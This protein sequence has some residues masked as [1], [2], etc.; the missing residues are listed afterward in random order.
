MKRLFVLWI[1]MLIGPFASAALPPARFIAMEVAKNSGSGAYQIEQDVQFPTSGEPLILRETW[2]VEN[3]NTM[4]LQ[5]TGLRELKEQFRLQYVYNGGQR[6]GNS[7]QGK[8]A[9][10]VADDFIEKYFHF[11]SGERLLNDIVSMKILPSAN[12][13]RKSFRN[14]KDIEYRPEAMVRLGRAGGNVAYVFGSPS[15]VE[16]NPHPGFWIEEDT[17]VLRKFRLPSLAEVTA[18]KFMQSPRGLLFPRSR[19]L[20]WGTNTVQIQTLSVSSKSGLKGDFFQP[21]SLESVN[22]MEGIEN[23]TLKATVEEFYLRFR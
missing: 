4:R 3:E 21:A 16:G 7:A 22:R 13:A 8:M 11:R 6:I 17:F 2:W 19:T 14:V 10:K 5:V 20:R 1:L 12:L 15:P 23:P 18:E 9:K